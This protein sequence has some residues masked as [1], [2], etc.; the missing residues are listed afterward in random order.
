MSR[1]ITGHDAGLIEALKNAGIVPEN[2]RRI[3]LDISYD[4]LVKIYY[5]VLA[6]KRL[7]NVDLGAHL[8]V[9]DK[10]GNADG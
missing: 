3:I 4:G 6:D 9:F 2:T 7:L 8:L 10:Q 1:P 5:E